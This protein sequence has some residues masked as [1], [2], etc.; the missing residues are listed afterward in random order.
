MDN[1]E[2]A[3]KI[4][5]LNQLLASVFSSV[6]RVCEQ[7]KEE[8]REVSARNVEEALGRVTMKLE[9]LLEFVQRNKAKGRNKRKN[10]N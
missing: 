4:Q 1:E 3:A 9:Y 8:R 2:L 10:V 7:L 6:G 5:K